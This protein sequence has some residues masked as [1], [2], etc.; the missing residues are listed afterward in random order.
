MTGNGTDLY[1]REA[2]NCFPNIY[3]DGIDDGVSR[4]FGL[5]TESERTAPTARVAETDKFASVPR[6]SFVMIIFGDYPSLKTPPC[7]LG[8]RLYFNPARANLRSSG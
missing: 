2:V 7:R 4:L 6:E 5:G 8:G 1:C 3:K